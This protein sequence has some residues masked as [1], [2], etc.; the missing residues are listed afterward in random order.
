M[1]KETIL[2]SGFKVTSYLRATKTNDYYTIEHSINDQLM[3][4][5]S[6]KFLPDE[7]MM[8]YAH[9]GAVVSANAVFNAISISKEGQPLSLYG[10]GC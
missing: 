9:R 5:D 6:F 3:T 1:I 4:V 8:R 7:D 2:D 10:S